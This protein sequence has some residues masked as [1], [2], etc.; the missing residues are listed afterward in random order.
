MVSFL[1]AATVSPLILVTSQFASAFVLPQSNSKPAF[2]LPGQNQDLNKCPSPIILGSTS[3][4][5]KK[6]QVEITPEDNEEWDFEQDYL[7]D[8]VDQIDSDED[9]FLSE[10]DDG[11][12]NNENEEHGYDEAEMLEALDEAPVGSLDVDQIAYLKDMMA[13][14]V[15]KSDNEEEET[16]SIVERLL[17]RLLEEWQ[18]AVAAEDENNDVDEEKI[19]ALQP[20]LEDFKMVMNAWELEATKYKRNRRRKDADRQEAIENIYDTLR[21]LY[22]DGGIEELKPDEE[23]MEI[24]LRVMATS[25]ERGT[26]RKVWSI[27]ESIRDNQIYGFGATCDMYESVIVCLAQSRDRG[28][29]ERAETILKEAVGLFRPQLDPSTNLPTGVS[30]EAF[31]KVLVSWA[32][33]GQDDGPKRAEQLIVFMDELGDPVKPNLSSFTTLIDAYAQQNDWDGVSYSERIFN[34]LLDEYMEGE[35]DE[36]PNIATWT[37]VISAW[38]RLAKKGFRGTEERADKLLKRMESLFEDGRTSFGPDAIAYVTC[39]NAWAFSKNKFGPTQAELI[40]N[41]MH[42]R[43]MD[44]DDTMKPSARSIQ[45]VID[46]W[47]K[48]GDEDSMEQAEQVL[49]RYEGHLDSLIPAED[50]PDKQRV[51]DDIATIYRTMLFGWSKCDPERAQDYLLDM[52]DRDM[53]LD[54]FSFDK[55]IEANVQLL[56]EDPAA[57]K[58]IY[59]IFEN[60]EKCRTDGKIQPNERVYTSFIRAMTRGRVKYLGTTANQ[61]LKRMDAL[62]SEGNKGIRPTVFTFNS[63]LNACAET[64]NTVDAKPM[65]AFKIALDIFNRLRE[66]KRD[67]LDH[68]SFG[69]MLKCSNLL[70]DCPQKNKFI[71]TTFKLCC[72][73]GLTNQFVL[74]DL[75]QCAPEDVWRPL[76]GCHAGEPDISMLPSEWSAA[77]NSKKSFSSSKNKKKAFRS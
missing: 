76:V 2:L 77:I 72:K 5:N 17:F 54:S 18:A 21:E 26:D 14:L 44:G 19:N 71:E 36:E 33:S 61:I 64:R 65:E 58:R 20:N 11:E 46:S 69:N 30:I 59:E 48:G 24:V 41:E 12:L 42:E 6:N 60:M 31:N 68:V 3:A 53:Q 70:P 22:E 10:D 1:E 13:Y 51:L 62:Y 23:I 15:S 25:R 43:Y 74:R 55:V 37:I 27:F 67:G 75:V 39:M 29:S 73:K 7:D 57:M 35:F 40:L 66:Q 56:P 4:P 34:R 47:S 38:T 32:K 45:I 52:V 16:A 50:D 49:D 9:E 28:S 63:V 8:D